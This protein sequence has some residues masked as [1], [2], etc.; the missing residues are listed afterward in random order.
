MKHIVKFISRDK[1]GTKYDKIMTIQGDVCL[2]LAGETIQLPEAG[3]S[4]WFVVIN[5]N[6]RLITY[7]DFIMEIELIG[8]FLLEVSHGRKSSESRV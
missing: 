6:F 3:G 8:D 2:P 7:P 4:I 1:Y 5:R